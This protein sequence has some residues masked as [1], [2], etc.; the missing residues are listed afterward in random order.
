M[1]EVILQT[2]WLLGRAALRGA[3][4]CGLALVIVELLST[5]GLFNAGLAAAGVLLALLVSRPGWYGLVFVGGLALVAGAPPLWLPAVFWIMGLVAE[6][7][8]RRF[9]QPAQ[10]VGR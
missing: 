4:A 7:A 3:A 6:L 2:T 10:E 1:G 9:D 8:S 5:G